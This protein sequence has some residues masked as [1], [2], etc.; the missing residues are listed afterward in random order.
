MYL[1]GRR[2]KGRREDKKKGKKI[3][4]R[5]KEGKGGCYVC[6]LFPSSFLPHTQKYV[7]AVYLTMTIY[8]DKAFNYVQLYELL[9]YLFIYLSLFLLS[10][11]FIYLSI[12]LLPL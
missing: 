4:R 7:S 5:R 9:S 11:L 8:T 6:S 2:R 3:K 10:Y 12:Y 1:K